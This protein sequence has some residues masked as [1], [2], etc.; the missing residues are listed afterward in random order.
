MHVKI[1]H[2]G[3]SYNEAYLLQAR[4]AAAT[5]SQ[6][7]INAEDIEEEPEQELPSPIA[8]STGNVTAFQPPT[9]F[10]NNQPSL[11]N[12]QQPVHSFHFVPRHPQQTMYAPVSPDNDYVPPTRAA[13]PAPLP[14]EEAQVPTILL[15]PPA[16]PLAD[17][18]K[19]VPLKKRS[20]HDLVH[21]SASSH[22]AESTSITEAHP[23]DNFPATKR[24]KPV[25]PSSGA[26]VRFEA[27][28]AAPFHFVRSDRNEVA[29]A[30]PEPLL[31]A[32]S[33]TNVGHFRR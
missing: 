5:L 10:S 30:A 24:F 14:L 22:S 31:V 9:S 2:A 3:V 32:E 28:G 21:L 29:P 1:K 23:T 20:F 11:S 19:S 27:R 17:S 25:I 12:T 13:P 16:A 7:G 26:F 15:Q 4:K 33:A 8:T 18:R 6:L